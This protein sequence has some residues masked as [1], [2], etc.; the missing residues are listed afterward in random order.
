MDNS[1]L[2][3]CLLLL[4]CVFS[5]LSTAIRPPYQSGQNS[6]DVNKI[7]GQW[8]KWGVWSSCSVRCGTGISS[9]TRRC[10]HPLTLPVAS[11]IIRADDS[12]VCEGGGREIRVCNKHKC[13][14]KVENVRQKQCRKFN[15]RVFNG[16]KYEWEPYI[17]PNNKCELTCR[18][19]GQHFYARLANRVGDGTPCDLTSFSVC[20]RRKCIKV[21]C[22]DLVGSNATLDK[23]GVCN[24]DNSTCRTISGVF[25]RPDLPRGYTKIT[26]I[27]AGSTGVNITELRPSNNYLSLRTRS[28]SVVN[29]NWTMSASG[30]YQAA[31]TTFIYKKQSRECPG[32]C[33]FARGPLNQTVDVLMLVYHQNPGVM[34]SFNVPVDVTDAYFKEIISRSDESHVLTRAAPPTVIPSRTA[35]VAQPE[36]AN[37]ELGGPTDVD[38]EVDKDDD[39]EEEDE[40]EE[41]TEPFREDFV[42]S[43][44]RHPHEDLEEGVMAR[45]DTQEDHIRGSFGQKEYTFH[46]GNGATVL[47]KANV[48]SWSD[49][50]NV[51]EEQSQKGP[52]FVLSELG[53]KGEDEGDTS[54]E[55]VDGAAVL[56]QQRGEQ[57][58]ETDVRDEGGEQEGDEGEQ[59]AGEGGEKSEEVDDGGEQEREESDERNDEDNS[60]SSHLGEEVNEAGDNGNVEIEGEKEKVNDFADEDE[61]VDDNEEEEDGDEEDG[62]DGD[63]DDSNEEEEK[64][65]EEPYDKSRGDEVLGLGDGFREREPVYNR[66]GY[67]LPNTVKAETETRKTDSSQGGYSPTTH[68]EVTT[69]ATP[70]T[71]VRGTLNVPQRDSRFRTYSR[72][73]GRSSVQPAI[74]RVGRPFGRPG[75]RGSVRIPKYS[76]SFTF[77]ERFKILRD[78]Q[79]KR[80]LRQRQKLIQ[81]SEVSSIAPSVNRRISSSSQLP[82]IQGTDTSRI[83]SQQGGIRHTSQ[84]HGQSTTPR[85]HHVRHRHHHRQAAIVTTPPPQRRLGSVDRNSQGLRLGATGERRVD[86]EK[87]RAGSSITLK[88]NVNASPSDRDQQS[89]RTY[90]RN[91]N[92]GVRTRDN[93]GHGSQTS[94]RRTS[95]GHQPS[96]NARVSHNIDRTINSRDPAPRPNQQQTPRRQTVDHRTIVD[97]TLPLGHFD[98][99]LDPRGSDRRIVIPQQPVGVSTGQQIIPQQ[100]VISSR[101]RYEGFGSTATQPGEP[102]TKYANGVDPLSGLP[103]LTPGGNQALTAGKSYT[104]NIIPNEKRLVNPTLNGGLS[105]E[106]LGA[107]Y[108]WRV[109]GFTDCTTTCGGGVQQTVVVCVNTRNQAV[110][111]DENCARLH[112]PAP[113]AVTCNTRPC[114]A[115]WE[116][117]QW[118]TCTTTCGPGTQTRTATC[119]SRVSAT[120]NL[121]M[122]DN[123]CSAQRPATAQTC[124]ITACYLWITGNWSKC[125]SRC[126]QG[127]RQR[128]VTCTDAAG[129]V[130]TSQLCTVLKPA[131]QENCNM[132]SC[133]KGWYSTQ[134]PEECPVSC[135]EGTM[136]RKTMCAGEKGVALDTDR[137]DQLDKPRVEKTCK[138]DTPCGGNWFV[139]EWS[140]CNGTCGYAVRSRDVACVKN[141][142]GGVLAVVTEDNCKG[143][144]KPETGEECQLPECHPEWYMTSWAECSKSCGTGY[145]TR[146]VKCLDPNQQPSAECPARSKPR[147]REPCNTQSCVARP[148]PTSKTGG[149]CTDSFSQCQLVKKARLCRYGYYAKMCCLSC[150]NET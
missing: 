91:E 115:S 112:K 64:E 10:E 13:P 50:A 109:S 46:K 62:N 76:Q 120:L 49:R 108:V 59:D 118:S 67:R 61:D 82:S 5:P 77:R 38:V 80:L 33:I 128:E 81:K 78:A 95:P 24:G 8:G 31:G 133:G 107:T 89:G 79:K 39:E 25:T 139:G 11:L 69:P 90:R 4:V 52:T 116:S 94:N 9:R 138:V 21:G 129:T 37:L 149:A 73:L 40:E 137:C 36:L 144:E 146:E 54:L 117:S 86:Q 136:K 123:S 97:E 12:V 72:S 3:D 98:R 140:K 17:N 6:R 41:A 119:K 142:P 85:S 68:V 55:V 93:Q 84:I 63:D 48:E 132:G 141:L 35:T 114:P 30:N 106:V 87:Q 45:P 148:K 135:G 47:L 110:V 60:E 42:E 125:S 99:A 70:A 130:V 58:V 96:L 18:A 147:T 105:N 51:H 102:L 14:P 65:E 7:A 121:T 53:S 101:P 88:A 150:S 103:P 66:R 113:T 134:W 15:A 56:K 1:R 127:R 126:G 57:M 19:K 44:G 143:K 83:R 20:I 104:R 43:H 23:C 74:R 111:T 124:E 131:N 71:T 32:E 100:P 27:P 122:P 34:Y 92:Q 29:G 28:K 145:R 2:I 75:R 16:K 26:T 22:D